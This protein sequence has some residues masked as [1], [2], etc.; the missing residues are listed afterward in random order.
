MAVDAKL[1]KAADFAKVSSIDF[2]ERFATNIKQLQEILGITRKI[3]KI[4]G[5]VIKTYKVTGTLEDGTVGEGEVI[6]LS[7]YKTEVDDTFELTVKKYRKQT[8]FEAIN[9]KGYEQA[10]DDT[11]N[12]MIK[13]IQNVIR[14]SFFTF[15]ATGTG[16]ATAKT[17]GL[18]GALAAAWGKNQVY[19]EDYDNSGFI[20]FVN[21]LD[22]ADYL[23]EK[24]IT[25]QTAFGM[26]Y[27]ENFLGLYDVLAYSGVPQGKV[28]TT[29][30]DN[31]ILYYAN[32]ANA[33]V[34]KAFDFTIDATGLIGIHRDVD[35]TTLTTDSTVISGSA[36]YAEL[37]SGVVKVDIKTAAAAASGTGSQTNPQG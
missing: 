14:N 32:P 13:D 27:I 36:L 2:V 15:L 21:P 20:Y 9:D 16:T 5:Q 37:I 33:E 1:M 12:K 26:T 30:K 7:K 4:P 22:I 18:Q 3:E 17:V 19:W 10:V 24:D 25:V 23:S 29:A 6:P 35:Y 34:A 11:D 31:I 28:Y 8:T